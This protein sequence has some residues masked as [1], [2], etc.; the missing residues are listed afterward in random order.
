MRSP[1]TKGPSCPPRTSLRRHPDRLRESAEMEPKHLV[2]MALQASVICTV[3]GFGLHASYRDTAYLLRRPGLLARSLVSV[4]LVM[5]LVAVALTL[6]FD[7]RPKLEVILVAL[8]ISPVPPL[9]PKKETRAGGDVGYALGLMIVLSLAAIV[10]APFAL[11]ILVRVYDY[12][13][14]VTPG[15]IAK[16]VSISVLVPLGAGMLL[17]ALLPRV[18]ERV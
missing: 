15:A 6:A 16:I 13:L 7:L 1:S 5:P 9:L 10:V 11:G 3:L 14:E 2:V 4:F 8:A 18:A 17:R 12:P